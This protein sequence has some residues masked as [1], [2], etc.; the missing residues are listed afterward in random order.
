M[1]GN[2][3]HL[4]ALEIATN[5]MPIF[6]ARH[7]T[8]LLQV[9]PSFAIGIRPPAVAD[10]AAGVEHKLKAFIWYHISAMV[11]PAL[12]SGKLREFVFADSS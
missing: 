6:Q 11:K 10:W 5:T 1:D 12:V 2:I 4:V 8:R 9:S 7:T 3:E